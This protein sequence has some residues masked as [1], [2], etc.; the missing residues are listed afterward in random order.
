M[1]AQPEDYRRVPPSNRLIHVESFLSPKHPADYLHYDRNDDLC[2]SH[3]KWKGT[4]KFDK[5]YFL[6]RMCTMLQSNPPHKSY[7]NFL[8]WWNSTVLLLVVFG[9]THIE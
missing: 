4:G 3:F 8:Q 1:G 9:G 6:C 2:N 5:V 7:E